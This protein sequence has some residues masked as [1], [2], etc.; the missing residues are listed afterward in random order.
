MTLRRRER[1]KRLLKRGSQKRNGQSEIEVAVLPGKFDRDRIQVKT[2]GA[3]R[4]IRADCQS[5]LEVKQNNL[6]RS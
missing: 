6:L 5:Y 4:K 1:K 3:R 2:N